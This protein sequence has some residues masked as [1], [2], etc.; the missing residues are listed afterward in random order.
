MSTIPD[1]KEEEGLADSNSDCK[2]F[3]ILLG[4]ERA[5][6]NHPGNRRFRAIINHNVHKY[7]TSSNKGQLVQKIFG[8]MASLGYQFLKKSSSSSADHVG[9]H[10]IC[11]DDA[12]DKISNALRDRVKEIG[13]RQRKRREEMMKRRK[14]TKE[15]KKPK[16]ESDDR[17]MKARLSIGLLALSTKGFL[18][19]AVAT[20]SPPQEPTT[21]HSSIQGFNL[22]NMQ[23]SEEIGSRIFD[24]GYSDDTLFDGLASEIFY[25]EA[26]NSLSFETLYHNKHDQILSVPV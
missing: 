14:S 3:Y 6:F 15:Q 10:I 18:S 12:R 11:D 8:D 7:S 26:E 19:A 17:K 4:K 9:W 20:S 2:L 5:I 16:T 13:K 21:S 23:E 1:F 25:S 22:M 24:A